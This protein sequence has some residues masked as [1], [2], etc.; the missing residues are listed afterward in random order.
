MEQLAPYFLLLI[1]GLACGSFLNVVVYRYQEGVSLLNPRSHCPGCKAS[2]QPRDLFPIL[3]FILLK[4]RCRY[5]GKGISWSYPLVELLSAG[6]FLFCF[7]YFK[8]TPL[9]F[10]YVVIF[11]LLLVLSCI[12]VRMHLL[13]N[14]FIFILFAWGF[15]WQF[16]YPVVSLGSALAGFFM[17]GGLFYVISLLSKGGM[18]GGDVKLM[19]ALGFLMGH[20][21]SIFLIFLLSFSLGAFVGVILLFLKKKTSK[22]PLALGPFLSLS[23]F[24]VTFWGAR[25]WEWYWLT[26]R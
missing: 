22:S 18:G 12:D 6:I 17:G 23:F 16:F 1:L 26:V 7:F 24:V 8:F 13:P 2:L 9:F 25:I 15:F 5:C 4:G 10:K 19:A 20:W 11:V 14:R 21:P 3:S